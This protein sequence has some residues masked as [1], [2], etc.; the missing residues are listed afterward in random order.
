MRALQFLLLFFLTACLI[1]SCSKG[2]SNN[3][4]G[5]NFVYDTATNLTYVD[6]QY[7]SWDTINLKWDVDSG[8][9]S[10]KVEYR[11]VGSINWDSTNALYLNLPLNT[12]FE[13]RIQT[14]FSA[15]NS[16]FTVSHYFWTPGSFSATYN[17]TT[18]EFR[19]LEIGTLLYASDS[20][21]YSWINGFDTVSLNSLG[22][23]QI[24]IGNNTSSFAC[25]PS[26]SRN[27]LTLQIGSNTYENDINSS[28]S[29]TR[30]VVNAYTASISFNCTVYNI[31]NP[32]DSIVITNG[33]YYGGYFINP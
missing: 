19:T 23:Q 27:V 18:H 13:W 12:L 10:Y 9:L 25:N 33:S 7:F 29:E 22:V 16:S 30:T 14:M 21:N 4:P 26:L 6:R 15:G 20:A 8:A 32:S 5:Q 28:G 11:P 31:S 17:G 1:S 24:G 2:H 3:H